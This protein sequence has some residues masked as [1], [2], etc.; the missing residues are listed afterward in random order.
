MNWNNILGE[1]TFGPLWILAN[2]LIINTN[3]R[4]SFTLKQFL[5]FRPLKIKRNMN[6]HKISKAWL[7]LKVQWGVKRK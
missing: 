1:K 2:I 7:S 4:N 5:E 3:F 6:I